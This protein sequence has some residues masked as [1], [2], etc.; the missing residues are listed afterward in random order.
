MKKLTIKNL[1]LVFT[2]VF[3]FSVILVSCKKS[4]SDVKL[5]D[6]GGYPSS[7][8]VAASNLVAYWD[9]DG[10][11]TETKSGNNPADAQGASYTNGVKGQALS[12]AN[13]YLYYTGVSGL[14]SLTSDFSVSAWFQVQNNKTDTSGFANEVFQYVSGTPSDAFGN[15][16]FSL[17]TGQFKHT[18]DAG[19]DTLIIHPTFRDQAGGLQD[20]TNN[21][22]VSDS[23]LVKDTTGTWVYSV[24]T[25]NSSTHQF[26]IYANGAKVGNFPDRGTSVFTPSPSTSAIIGAWSSNIPALGLPA[27]SFAQPFTGAIDEVRVYSKTLSKDEIS[28][29][30]ELGKAGR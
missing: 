25:W 8:A 26:N 12:L 1:S 22:P 20:N 16:N 15:I 10:N 24:I 18:P 17:E 19:Y 2:G 21:Y 6:I 4:K 11:Q 29:L 13:G 5:P 9:F 30:Y 28:A 7:N 14:T 23:T 27:Q 3:L